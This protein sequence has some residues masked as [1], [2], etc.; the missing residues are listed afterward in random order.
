MSL[1]FFERENDS[2]MTGAFMLNSFKQ[3]QAVRW[4]QTLF[5]WILLISNLRWPADFE[6]LNFKVVIHL[7]RNLSVTWPGLILMANQMMWETSMAKNVDGKSESF[8]DKSDGLAKIP[9]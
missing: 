4:I 5:L 6:G 8:D 1:S 2:I 3:Q 9:K 7:I